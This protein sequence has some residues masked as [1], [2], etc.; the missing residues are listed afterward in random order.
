MP[1]RSSACALVAFIAVAACGQR[2]APQADPAAEEP[3]APVVEPVLVQVDAGSVA[4]PDTVAPGWRLVR[5]E[6][7]GA[8]HIPVIFLMQDSA[9]TFD[10]SAFLRELDEGVD[11]PGHALAL[12]GPEVGDSGEV[13]IRFTPGRYL[14]ACVIRGED[15]H[16]HAVAGEARM[17][18]VPDVPPAAGADAPP[19]ASYLVRMIDFAYMGPEDWE[20]GQQVLRVDNAGQQDHQVR[21]ARLKAGS[22]MRDWLHAE[23]PN[24]HATNIAG[25][26]RMGS[27]VVAYLPV[28]LPP[29]EYVIY[30]L[31]PDK[32]SGKPHVMLGMLRAIHVK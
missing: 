27:G 5:V 21:I 9:S 18:V 29:G 16:R 7:D 11:T 30:C 15:G 2:D 32:D 6:E 10:A 14:L 24:D 13:F 4:A 26:A 31:V 1:G 8:G 19:G 20:A 23:E 3:A 17:F 12:G 28:D 25:V 22:T